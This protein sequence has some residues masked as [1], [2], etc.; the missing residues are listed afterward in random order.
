MSP[1]LSNTTVVWRTAGH[2]R[3]DCQILHSTQGHFFLWVWAKVWIYQVQRTWAWSKMKSTRTNKHNKK[4]FMPRDVTLG[5]ITPLNMI[6]VLF[7]LLWRFRY[8][9]KLQLLHVRGLPTNFKRSFLFLWGFICHSGI[10]LY[11]LLWFGKVTYAK[12]YVGLKPH[13]NEERNGNTSKRKS[14]DLSH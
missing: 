5:G 13:G 4:K 1:L 2:N 9:C 14:Q 6:G 12:H 11:Y 10:F 3:Q 7:S 8:M